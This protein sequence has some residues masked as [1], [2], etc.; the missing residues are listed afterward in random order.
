MKVCSVVVTYGNRFHLLRQVI[1]ALLREKVSRIIVVDNNSHEESRKLLQER[2]QELQGLLT[3]IYLQENTGSAGGFKAGLEKAYKCSDCEYIWLLDDDNVPEINALEIL[4]SFWINYARVGNEKSLC[5]LSYRGINPTYKQLAM[6]DS[7]S[8]EPLIGSINAFMGFNVF[9]IFEKRNRSKL[10]VAD[11]DEQKIPVHKS[12]GRVP[13]APYGGMFFHKSLLDV[14]GYPD[15]RLFLYGDDY[16]FSYRIVRNHGE[17]V[18]LIDSR[19]TD[20]DISENKGRESNEQNLFRLY[21][22]TRNLAYFQ[23]K[24][25]ENHWVY[26]LNRM[27]FWPLSIIKK[28]AEVLFNRANRER[29]DTILMAIRDG[30]QE[31]LGKRN[32]IFP[33][34]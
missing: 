27:I 23:K 19:I 34:K 13:V 3:V 11:I 25:A 26:N 20:I 31:R 2:E 8:I 9:R 16:E 29:T 32:D 10:F 1:D 6:L 33:I 30:F 24:V 5:L 7:S 12:H 21:Y 14:I 15:E 4:T 28:R 22:N 17:I 18:L